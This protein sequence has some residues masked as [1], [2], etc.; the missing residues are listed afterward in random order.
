MSENNSGSDE[1]IGTEDKFNET[2]SGSG[3]SSSAVTIPAVVAF[4]YRGFVTS[5]NKWT[6]IC[7]KCNKKLS[8]HRGVTSAFTK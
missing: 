4:A 1:N 5:G 6:A 2:P 7:K 8:E 3:I